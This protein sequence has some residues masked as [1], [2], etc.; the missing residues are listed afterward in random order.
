MTLFFCEATLNQDET[1]GQCDGTEEDCGCGGFR[2]GGGSG[3]VAVDADFVE[4]TTI[5]TGVAVGDLRG[6]AE[7][8]VT[9]N[10]R[11]AGCGSDGERSYAGPSSDGAVAE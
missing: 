8:K 2:D 5:S 7:V 6:E 11:G 10:N 1:G 3:F 4:V 9:G